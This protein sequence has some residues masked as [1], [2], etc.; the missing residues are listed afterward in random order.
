MINTL[1]SS[2]MDTIRNMYQQFRDVWEFYNM[3]EK[4]TTLEIIVGN[5]TH[6][7]PSFEKIKELQKEYSQLKMTYRI[8]E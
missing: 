2:D 5:Q 1:V 4:E 6:I 8:N 7:D 3:F